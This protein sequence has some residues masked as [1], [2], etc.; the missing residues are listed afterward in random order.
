[1]KTWHIEMAVVAT[2][3]LVLNIV[4]G[5]LFTI[6]AL[7]AVAVLLTFG[8]AQV[9]DRM[10]EQEELREKPSVNCFRMLWFYFI[11]KEIFWLLYFFLNHSFSALVGVITFLLYPAWRRAYRRKYPVN[12]NR[13]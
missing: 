12:A 1:M 9:A 7:A 5:K 2:V 4:T 6:E 10:A 3:L 11:G 8:H 13:H